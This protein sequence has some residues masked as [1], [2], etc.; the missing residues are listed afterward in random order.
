MVKEQEMQCPY[1]KIVVWQ[2]IGIISCIIEVERIFKIASIMANFK[3]LNWVMKTLKSL[4]TLQKIGQVTLMLVV[5][6]QV[7]HQ[8]QDFFF[9]M[10]EILMEATYWGGGLWCLQKARPL[11]KRNKPL[12]V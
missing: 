3:G 1:V 11:I 9:D 10:E 7:H 2:F 5:H 6:H 8:V 4:W 12:E